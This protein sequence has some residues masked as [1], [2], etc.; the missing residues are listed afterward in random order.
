MNIKKIIMDSRHRRS[1]DTSAYPRSNL[2]Q[3]I[4]QIMRGNSQP[5]QAIDKRV[6]KIIIRQNEERGGLT[7]RGPPHVTVERIFNRCLPIN[8][9]V[10]LDQPIGGQ[11]EKIESRTPLM[12]SDQF[13]LKK[14]NPNKL[15]NA[16]K[17][18][19]FDQLQGMPPVALGG[20]TF[21]K[22]ELN[23]IIKC[24]RDSNKL[25]TMLKKRKSPQVKV[26]PGQMLNMSLTSSKDSLGIGLLEDSIESVDVNQ[27]IKNATSFMPPRSA[28][29]HQ[30]RFQNSVTEEEV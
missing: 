7:E 9:E 24:S 18:F 19:Y 17:S 22:N 28:S 12:S 15:F 16:L 6:K 25:N 3:A 30:V 8:K 23:Q 13:K 21:N 11:Y 5:K 14:L 29:H 1:Q 4:N 10:R 2:L 20:G 27:Q 26:D